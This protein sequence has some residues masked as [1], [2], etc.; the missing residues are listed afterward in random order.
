[1]VVP[2]FGLGLLTYFQRH[3][4]D[5]VYPIAIDEQEGFRP[6][7]L[8]AI[9]AIA[10]HFAQRNDPAIVTMPTG[11]GKTA[12]MIACAFVLRAERVL[13]VTPSRMVREQ[14]ADEITEL[15]LLRRIGA[16]PDGIERP[17][18]ASVSSRVGTKESWQALLAYDVVVGTVHSISPEMAGVAEPDRDQFDVLLIDEAHHS[19]ARTWQALLK[20]FTNARRILFTATPFRRDRREIQG[21]FVYTYDLNR[22]H[23]DGVFSQIR[24]QPVDP[25]ES[26]SAR[27]VAVAKAAEIRFRADREAG[28]HHLLMVR[29]DRKLRAAELAEIYA[30]HTSL[31]L[32]PL[33]SD[34]SL[35]Y[36]KSVV[37]KLHTGELDGIITVNML[38]E[39]FD[40]PRL[41]IAA[42]HAPHKSL[43]ATLQFIG[44]FA[45]TGAEHIGGA[46]FLAVPEDIEIERNKLFETGASWQD[47]VE[48][49]SATQIQSEIQT[50]EMLS[51]FDHVES[52]APDLSDLSL[53]SLE[54]Y[55]HVKVYRVD[56]NVDLEAQ[57]EF[58]ENAVVAY[59][60]FSPALRAAVW[61]TR[62]RSLVRWSKDER[63][64]NIRHDLFIA[65]YDEAAGLLFICASR[66][67]DGL[68]ENLARQVMNGNPRILPLARI[69]RA[70]NGLDALEFFNVGMRNRVVGSQTESYRIIAGSNAAQAI[71]PSDARLYHRGHCFG[72]GEG[73]GG[74]VTIG[75]SSASKIWSNRTSRLPELISW[76]QELARRIQADEIVTTG[77]GLDYLSVGEEV[78]GLPD[79]IFWADWDGTIYKSPRMIRFPV[80]GNEIEG[81]LLD[82]DIKIDYAQSSETHIVLVFSND[83]VTFRMTFSFETDRLFEPASQREP[84]IVV[85]SPSQEVPLID[86][87]NDHPLCFYTEDL[88]VLRGFD[89]VRPGA[90][91]VAVFERDGIEAVPW[92]GHGIDPTREFGPRSIHDFMERRLRGGNA[93]VVYYDHGTGEVADFIALTERG[94]KVEVELFHCKAAG[95][96]GAGD[97]VDDAYEVC[98][99]AVKSVIWTDPHLLIRRIDRRF[100]EGKG[101]CQFVR[102]NVKKLKE[103]MGRPRASFHFRITLV[104]PGFGRDR[105]SAKIANLLAATNDYLVRGGF[106][107][108]HVIG[109]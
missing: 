24:Y 14:I 44:R 22:A 10:G 34:H 2:S 81:Q 47:I 73:D 104:Q 20:Y 11:S 75:V 72:T 48:N 15:S 80:D 105:L 54:P 93:D 17:T 1:M 82:L 59:R 67:A 7:Q 18:V 77:S 41:K 79:G 86:F 60:A 45:R 101:A 51:S 57:I 37:K 36:T 95:G 25:Q 68:Y 26:Q 90:E 103:I 63:I 19:S 12:V 6:P 31:R 23:A 27:D 13:V 88:G 43:A 42:V 56:G 29:T 94:E 70:L 78:D 99:Q 39:G 4:G 46:T 64:V 71:L 58:P 28:F 38:G 87:V 49:L 100:N 9:H 69:N 40:L 33:S 98:G 32:V 52:F 62:D 107:S 92:E 84:P 74:R 61:V 8:G 102:G 108:L 21:R 3:Y 16:L 109:S 106:I 76:C 55:H 85:T 66:R 5:F 50:R 91:P 83:L 30:N 35:R 97:R 65:Y 89:L 53:Y 96:P